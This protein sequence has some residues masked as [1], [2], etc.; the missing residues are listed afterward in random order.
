MYRKYYTS[1]K[2][3]KIYPGFPLNNN[4]KHLPGIGYHKINEVAPSLIETNYNEKYFRP[5]KF[6]SVNTMD[7]NTLILENQNDN[8][9]E[10]TLPKNL[11]DNPYDTIIN[12]FS[13]LREANQGATMKVGCGTVGLEAL[14]YPIAYAFFS[15]TLKEQL[16]Y[17]QYLKL[18]ENIYHINLIKMKYLNNSEP[19]NNSYTFL[20]EIETIEGECFCYY[21][22]YLEVIY[23]NYSY[24]INS[25]SFNKEDFFCAPYHG[26]QHNAE[27]AVEVMYKNWCNL[28]VKLYPTQQEEYIKKIM[29][30]GADGN[31]YLFVFFVLTN[32]TNIEIGQYKKVN[33]EWLKVTIN[34]YEC[35]K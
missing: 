23:E 18:F 35:L 29:A 9:T 13:I 31:Q 30:D 1:Q 33:D 15:S 34:P 14:P 4:H 17:D 12:F 20:I 19:S 2:S 5:S 8:P 11:T 28:I 10:I 32:G 6:P 16:P 22:G 25:L 21:Y 24:L 26:W 27:L 3:S 7:F